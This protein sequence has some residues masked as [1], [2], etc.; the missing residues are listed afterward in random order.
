MAAERFA[1]LFLLCFFNPKAAACYFLLSLF[2]PPLPTPDLPA[3]SNELWSNFLFK[4]HSRST[5]RHLTHTGPLS[6]RHEGAEDAVNKL[7]AMLDGEASLQLQRA[8]VVHHPARTKRCH[9]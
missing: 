6:E 4:Y 8:L 1:N 7:G 2:F 5:D 3:A 9:D